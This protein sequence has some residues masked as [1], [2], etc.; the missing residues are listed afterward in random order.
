MK[1]TPLQKAAKSIAKGILWCFNRPCFK[2]EPWLVIKPPVEEKPDCNQP[3][4]EKGENKPRW[5]QVDCQFTPV[6]HVYSG[7]K[8][9]KDV[10]SKGELN[11]EREIVPYFRY[12]QTIYN[13]RSLGPI[14]DYHPN[15]GKDYVSV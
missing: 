14:F 9:V 13:K 12:E 2:M 3:F 8:F 7:S 1:N 10:H 11:F 4:F 15:D 5:Q 6:Y